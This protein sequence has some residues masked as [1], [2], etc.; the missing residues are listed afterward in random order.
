M[1]L[2]H[3]ALD[4]DRVGQRINNMKWRVI[5]LGKSAFPLLTS[6]WPAEL[7]FSKGVISLPIGPRSIF[8]ASPS[9]KTL[10][11]ISAAPP[12]KLSASINTFIVS[13]ARRYVY[14]QDDTQTA[15]IKKY[16]GTNQEPSPLWP[17]LGRAHA[18]DLESLRSF[19]ED[20]AAIS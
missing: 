16:F 19:S 3:A 8:V 14:A 1:G 6:D 9:D 13:R 2:L 11:Q 20:S 10:D 7:A 4:N 15:L 5:K 17:S 18:L 12:R